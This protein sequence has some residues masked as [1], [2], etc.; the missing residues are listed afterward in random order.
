[1]P[2]IYAELDAK[3]HALLTPQQ[4]KLFDDSLTMAESCR[5]I[6]RR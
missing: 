3:L 4:R 2:P 5:G 6:M 1:M